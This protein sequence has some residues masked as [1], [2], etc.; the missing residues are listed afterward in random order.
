MKVVVLHVFEISQ[1]RLGGLLIVKYLQV[2]QHAVK[3]EKLPWREGSC[4]GSKVSYADRAPY[5]Q[6][7]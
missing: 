5:F 6:L 7:N 2:E 1:L 4:P 3:R